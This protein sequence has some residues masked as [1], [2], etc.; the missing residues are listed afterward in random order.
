VFLDGG[1]PVVRP[2][3]ELRGPSGYTPR[4][5]ILDL[6]TEEK[7]GFLGFIPTNQQT[8]KQIKMT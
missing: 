7:E 6:Q 2:Q 3:E 8:N 1:A 5:F 4:G